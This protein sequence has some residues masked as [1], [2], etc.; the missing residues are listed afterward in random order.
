[1]QLSQTSNT[2]GDKP[3]YSLDYYLKKTFGE[4][5]YKIAL[6]GGCTCPNRDGT[7]GTGGCIFCSAGGSGDFAVQA[8]TISLQIELAIQRLESGGKNIGKKYIAYFQSFSNTY[9]P[10]EKLRNM[11][12]EALAHPQVVGLAI[13]TRPDCFSPE[14]YQLLDECNHIKPTWVE[15]GLQTIHEETAKYI[16][17][18]YPL[19][20]FEECVSHLKK[21]NVPI[22]VHTIIGLPGETKE[23]MIATVKYL[24]RA[25]IHGIKLQL[26]HILKD[27]DLAKELPHL[28][29]LSQE[30]Y[31]QLVLT[32]IG[33]LSKDIVV[34][35]ITGDG[36][37]NLLLA[38]LWSGNKRSVLNHIA[39][40]FK[41][42]KMYQGK[43]LDMEKSLC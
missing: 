33:W 21:T 16:R 42:Q 38:P 4:K 7:L 41:H 2:W 37:K 25:G 31:V 11:Y 39:K 6:E 8:D 24:N 22:V 30:E 14:I 15:L 32:L 20:V 36:P 35:R 10:I 34:H 26:L 1:M 43:Y 3:Y 17:R 23:D 18:G 28:H 5:I 40:E 19:S 12:M 13:G 27:T 29:I 9:A